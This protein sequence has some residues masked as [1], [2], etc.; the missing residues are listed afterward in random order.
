MQHSHPARKRIKIN[1]ESA[2]KADGDDWDTGGDL[3]NLQGQIQTDNW[4][5]CDEHWDNSHL[6][7][8]A[9]AS[10]NTHWDVRL[11]NKYAP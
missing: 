10:S 8:R 1:A 4:D 11:K 3:Q 6:V 7:P 5:V 9:S 2:S